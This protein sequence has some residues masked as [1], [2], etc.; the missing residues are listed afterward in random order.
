MERGVCVGSEV[1]AGIAA[2][3]QPPVA[4]PSVVATWA[5]HWRL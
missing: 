5:P 2:P 1:I 3:A 4:S